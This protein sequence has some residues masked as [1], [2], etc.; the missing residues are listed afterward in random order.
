MTLV[1]GVWPTE[2]ENG[3]DRVPS[4]LF[5]VIVQDP[6]ASNRGVIRNEE[7]DTLAICNPPI[8]CVLPTGGATETV[9][10]LLKPVPKTAIACGSLLS[11]GVEGEIEVT[12]GR[13]A[14]TTVTMIDVAGTN[15][16][17]LP[18]GPR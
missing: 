3:L 15:A 1:D 14:A 13:E 9:S 2:N 10:P 17:V 4:G 12:V 8:V 7:D 11:T 5:T 6:V 18:F 16:G